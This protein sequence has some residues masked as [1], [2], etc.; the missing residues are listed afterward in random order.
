[1]KK[2]L[3]LIL[4]LILTLT[5]CVS[6]ASCTRKAG[7]PSKGLSYALNEAGDAYTVVSIG[8]CKDKDVLIPTEY[9]GLPVTAIGEYAFKGSAVE[10][11]TVTENIVYIEGNAFEKCASLKYNVHETVSYIGTETNPYYALVVASQNSKESFSIHKDTKVIASYALYDCSIKELSLPEG[12]THIGAGAF[13][14]CG[15]MENI[16]LPDTLTYIGAE[17]FGNCASL[18]SIELPASLSFIGDSAFMYC[19]KLKEISFDGTAEQWNKVSSDGWNRY[20]ND[21]I[22]IACKK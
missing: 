1:M 11:I 20:F 12:I 15:A 2:F 5:L 14:S 7:E 13:G 3:S 22:S 16:T 21:E 6:L 17:A 8:K 10:K 19:M 18:K 4:S 9:K